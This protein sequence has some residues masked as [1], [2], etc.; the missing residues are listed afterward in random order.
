MK[1]PAYHSANPSDPDVHHD[2]SDCPTGQQIP[3][4]N[5]RAGAGGKRR[6]EHCVKKG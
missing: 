1:V 5:L 6:C 2:H 3:R 4:Y